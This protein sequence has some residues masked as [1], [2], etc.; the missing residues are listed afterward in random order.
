MGGPAQRPDVLLVEL[1]STRGLRVADEEL[2]GSLERA[3]ACVAVACAAHPG[4]V[5]TLALT[6]LLWARSARRAAERKLRRL[7]E[8][9]APRSVIYSTT[10]AALL[11]PRPG[12]LRFDSPAAANRPGR[13]GLWQRPLE[14]R[15]LRQ[16]PLLLPSSA[17][18]LA[19]AS[20]AVAG[21]A[22]RALVVPVPI[23]LPPP[24]DG[25]ERDIAA[26]TYAANPSKKGLDRVLETWRRVRRPSEQ[27]VV[28]G[29]DRQRL[30][31]SG[32]DVPDD[33][34]LVAGML[35]QR[36]YRALLRRSRV[37]LCAPRREE[38]GIA[39]L[40]ALAEGCLLV[41]APAPGGYVALPIA[42]ELDP[43]LV[44]EDLGVALR[45]ALD[46]PTAG[47][48][49]RAHGL[50]EPL[51]A[52]AVDRIVAEQLLPRLLGE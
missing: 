52:A 37:F 43:R 42:R 17:G 8:R 30:G 21:C 25:A 31:E 49:L 47:Y 13:H 33:G 29:I 10:T 20:S 4:D 2:V 1:G 5:R 35:S 38:Y 32:F 9:L 22:E 6:D 44:G 40:E 39:Q 36:E 11:W 34:V 19:E 45:H 28:A 14:R 7:G 51:T 46:A 3:G 18:A 23:A 12:A 50:L 16:A 24:D 15:R 48:C 27:L 41:T 26:I